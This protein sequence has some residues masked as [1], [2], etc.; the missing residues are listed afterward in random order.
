M[1]C[2]CRYGLG[3]NTHRFVRERTRANMRFISRVLTSKKIVR[4]LYRLAKA[5]KRWKVALVITSSSSSSSNVNAM[6]GNCITK[7]YTNA[8]QMENLYFSSRKEMRIHIHFQYPIT[9]AIRYSDSLLQVFNMVFTFH[10]QSLINSIFNPH[11]TCFCWLKLCFLHLDIPERCKSTKQSAYWVM[12]SNK[13]EIEN[14]KLKPATKFEKND[15]FS[16]ATF[17]SMTHSYNL[18]FVVD[19]NIWVCVMKVMKTEK[20]R[21]SSCAVRIKAD[22][23]KIYIFHP[24]ILKITSRKNQPHFFLKP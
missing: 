14:Q 4:K 17:E 19:S 12:I 10:R 6:V 20:E 15:T 1:V 24:L 21:R 3:T 16:P 11:S 23:Q 2:P 5:I 8:S 18:D 13:C 9:K 7:W 22:H